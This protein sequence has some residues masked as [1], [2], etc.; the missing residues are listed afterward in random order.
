MNNHDSGSQRNNTAGAGLVAG[1]VDPVQISS[2][3]NN[4]GVSPSK[5]PIG[6]AP[7]NPSA[8][9]NMGLGGAQITGNTP[10]K[11]RRKQP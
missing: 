8:I 10:L 1:D 4:D 9:N 6:A 2:L 3:L 5:M 7:I 11:G